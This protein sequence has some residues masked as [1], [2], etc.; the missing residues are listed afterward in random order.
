MRSKK[1]LV[2][3]GIFIIIIAIAVLGF[4]NT[5]EPK[6]YALDT[7]N[8]K[9][10]DYAI[11]FRGPISLDW[12]VVSDTKKDFKFMSQRVVTFNLS[13]KSSDIGTLVL[14]LRNIE[15]KDTIYFIKYIPKK[16]YDNIRAI[17]TALNV[18]A[19]TGR[20]AAVKINGR[21]IIY[22]G[23]ISNKTSAWQTFDLTKTFGE[24][25]PKNAVFL[26]SSGYYLRLGLVDIYKPL[27][28]MVRQE[29]Y[30]KSPQIT[31]MRSD[32]NI[33][34]IIPLPGET[35]YF[36]ENW[37]ILSNSPLID[38]NKQAAVEDARAGDL[39]RFRKLSTD[40]IYYL[41]PWNYYPTEKTAF[42]LNPASNY[43]VAGL[44]SR[45]NAGTYFKDIMISSM[46]SVIETQNKDHYWLTTPRSDWL[47]Q[48]YGIP[49]GFYDTRFNT[50]VAEFML[51]MYKKTGEKLALQA[52]QNYAI[53][54][55]NYVK[56]Q[57][58]PTSGGGMLVP[59]YHK[60]GLNHKKTNVSL[61]HLVSEMNFLYRLYLVDNNSANLK[62]GNLIRQAVRDTGRSWIKPNGDLHYAYL[63]DGKYGTQDYPLLTLNDLRTAQK[64]ISQVSDEK[65]PDDVFQILINSKEQYLINNKMPIR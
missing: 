27:K 50:D 30:E 52:A 26:D 49:A 56:Q 7:N 15:N 47:Y 65:Q 63:G 18:C 28:N 5:G 3:L 25:L 37:G 29:M 44:F 41:T 53:W 11:T 36:V 22:K 60:P 33:D 14:T 1:A 16:N 42:W 34:Y 21:Q 61:N 62:T 48:E 64:L 13:E 23:E 40:G 58:I 31:V 9:K 6:T 39:V 10:P 35:G 20:E 46:Y 54:L 38:W 8:D 2:F 43:H 24:K 19:R 51:D 4:K 12:K 45:Q 55:R 17:I 32:T 57:G 59:D